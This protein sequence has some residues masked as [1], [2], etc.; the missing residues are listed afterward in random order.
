MFILPVVASNPK[1]PDVTT[2]PIQAVVDTGSE[3][4]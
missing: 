4:T 3:Y 2:P 1:T